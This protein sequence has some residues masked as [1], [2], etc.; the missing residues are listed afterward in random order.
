MKHILAGDLPAELGEMHRRLVETDLDDPLLACAPVLQAGFGEN[1]DRASSPDG[2][3]WPARKSNRSRRTPTGALDEGL[4]DDTGA[5]KA[6]ATG[7]GAGGVVRVD[8]G[9]TLLVG[10]DKSV[11]LG[12]LGGAAVHNFGYSPQNIPQREYLAVSPGV[13]DACV[14]TFIDGAATIVFVF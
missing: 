9:R 13:L 4:L 7:E 8:G 2:T 5:L 1:F 3:V 10:V 12:G 14:D 6:A 11:D